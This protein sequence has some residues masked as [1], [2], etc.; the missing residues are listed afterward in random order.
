MGFSVSVV[1]AVDYFESG[2]YIGGCLELASGAAAVIPGVG[3]A[4]SIIIDFANFV[5]DVW[6]DMQKG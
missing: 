5:H 6:N 3:T 4:I 2:N 1:F